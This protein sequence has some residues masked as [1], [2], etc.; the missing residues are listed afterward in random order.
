[1]LTLDSFTDSTVQ[2]TKLSLEQGIPFELALERVLSAEGDKNTKNALIRAQ[3][4][5]MT[6]D[7]L[8][9]MAKLGTESREDM[10]QVDDISKV[11]NA[12]DIPTGYLE[13][14]D[15]KK[16]KPIQ[17]GIKESILNH[18]VENWDKE[19]KRPVLISKDNWI[20]DGHHRVKAAI[21]KNKWVRVI[22]IDLPGKKALTAVKKLVNNE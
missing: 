21:K 2:A 12:E 6:E 19:G 13:F 8:E 9:K 15:P 17:K 16:L 4:K 22:R 14:V 11:R 20:I 5:R 3:I 1:M 18:I 7:A 10:P